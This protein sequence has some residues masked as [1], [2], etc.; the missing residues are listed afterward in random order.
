[1]GKRTLAARFASCIASDGILLRFLEL[2]FMDLA[3]D[4]A[5]LKEIIMLSD[6]GHSAVVHDDDLIGIFQAGRALGDDK[7]CRLRRKQM[8]SPSQ[9]GVRRK[10]ECAEAVVQ[11]E[12][13]RISDKSPRDGET[14]TLASG[15]IAASLLD[16]LVEPACLAAD[17]FRCLRD[18]EGFP[19]FLVGGISVRPQ[20]VLADRA[21]KELGFLHD[22]VDIAAKFIPP[23]FCDRTA[24]EKYT[25]FRGVIEA[26]DQADQGG[27]AAAGPADDADRLTLFCSEGDLRDALVARTRIGE[28][29]MVKAD[30]FGAVRE[31]PVSIFKFHSGFCVEDLADPVQAGER[32]AD[33]DDRV[34]HLDELDQD[35]AHVVDQRDDISAEERPAVDL[36]C[37]DVENGNDAEVDD[38]I[39]ERIHEGGDLSDTGL[40]GVEGAVG[41]LKAGDL[42][43]LFSEGTDHADT[44]QILPGDAHDPVETFLDI[45]VA[46]AGHAHDGKYDDGEYRDRHDEDQRGL[47]VDRKGHDHRTEYDEGAA[48]KKAQGHIDAVL[49][50]ID[51]ACDAGD[52]RARTDRIE[53]LEIK[54]LDVAEEI[55]AETRGSF[56][57]RTGGEVLGSDAAGEADESQ[58][59]EEKTLA[60]DI[61]PV[62]SADADVDNAGDDERD[63]GRVLPAF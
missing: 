37:A 17:D 59:D 36:A 10:V 57:G 9:S 16:R 58:G 49:D 23:E 5:G 48:Q 13:F 52:E 29:D 21:L 60:D 61:G 14:L 46:G 22:D 8:K 2:A 35:L 45:S 1:M 15:E 62:I 55:A 50:L 19:E 11:N 56:S 63:E 4:L 42:I 12:D 20:K 3:V 31:R 18:L 47:K 39:G 38:D 40:H 30:G 25:A 27:L 34:C 53:C 6:S 41:F 26:G 43:L 28:T 7:D 33:Q 24:E 32:L 44:G 54:L 51:V